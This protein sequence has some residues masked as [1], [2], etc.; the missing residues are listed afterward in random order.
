MRAKQPKFHNVIITGS[1]FVIFALVA[2][3]PAP[4][5]TFPPSPETAAVPTQTA[6]QKGSWTPAQIERGGRI[7][8]QYCGGCHGIRGEGTPIIGPSLN[9]TG[10]TPHDSL[11][12][13]R[14]K[15]ENGFGNMPAYKNRLSDQQ[16]D[17]VITWFQSLWPEEVYQNWKTRWYGDDPRFR[18]N[19]AQRET[20]AT[21]EDAQ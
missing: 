8:S 3:S 1:S 18:T 21:E 7:Y 5:N 15:I 13:L 4:V 14:D 16:I 20:M 2:C 19:R 12:V 11:H 9:G 17:D 6:T 10:Y